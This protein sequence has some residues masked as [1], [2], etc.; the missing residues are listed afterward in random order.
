VADIDEQIAE[1][2][3]R[4]A[5]RGLVELERGQEARVQQQIETLRKSRRHGAAAV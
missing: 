3:G 1:L 5:G 4:L 2:E